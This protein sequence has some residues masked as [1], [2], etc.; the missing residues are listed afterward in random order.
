MNATNLSG[1]ATADPVEVR[2]ALDLLCKPGAVYELRALDTPKG[3]L[4]GYFND[5]GEATANAVAADGPEARSA[6]RAA[7]GKR[8]THRGSW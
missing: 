4:S 2:R 6:L 3:T 1:P 8:A 5:L 7:R